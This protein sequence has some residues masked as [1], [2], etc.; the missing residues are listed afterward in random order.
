MNNNKRMSSSSSSSSSV[1]QPEEIV[2]N[3]IIA[4]LQKDSSQHATVQKL[5]DTK[6]QFIEELAKTNQQLNQNISNIQNS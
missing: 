2:F 1:S 5:L 3:N 4:A 6:S